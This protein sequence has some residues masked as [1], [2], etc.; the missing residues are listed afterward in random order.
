[1]SEINEYRAILL[2][3]N[4]QELNKAC[5]K[6]ENINLIQIHAWVGPGKSY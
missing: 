1:M 5:F 2:E 4:K 3:K 6:Q